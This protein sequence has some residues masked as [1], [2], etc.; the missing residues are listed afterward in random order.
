MVLM[1]GLHAGR[2]GEAAEGEDWDREHL[3]FS[4]AEEA[5]LKAV[6]A[7]AKSPIT[8]VIMSGGTIDASWA[9]DSPKVGAVLQ[10]WYPGQA[11][12]EAIA[13]ILT[14]EEAPSGRLPVTIYSNEV[15]LAR[16]PAITEMSMTA[17]G[18]VTAGYDTIPAVR[19]L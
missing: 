10:S 14:G 2:P 11:G 13:R 12:G 4:Y 1:L 8:L 7:V 17:G 3:L 5:L 16:R 18:G 6:A 19:P 15:F 9:F